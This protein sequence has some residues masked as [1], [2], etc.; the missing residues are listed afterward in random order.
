MNQAAVEAF[1]QLGRDPNTMMG[2]SA[3]EVFPELK[4][5]IVEREVRRAI[6]DHVMI[7]YEE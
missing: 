3:W 5:S 7:K 1:R 2:K 6:E 4:G